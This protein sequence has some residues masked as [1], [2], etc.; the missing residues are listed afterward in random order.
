MASADADGED[1]PAAR[2]ATHAP[3]RGRM[4]STSA[5]PA[6]SSIHGRVIATRCSDQNGTRRKLWTCARQAAR[7]HDLGERGDQEQQ[8]EDDLRA[9]AHRGAGQHAVIG[10]PFAAPRSTG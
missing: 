6:S 2:R 3:A 4:P 8:P 5:S 10:P 9:A 7:V 1:R